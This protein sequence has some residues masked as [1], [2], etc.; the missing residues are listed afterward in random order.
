MSVLV[1]SWILTL[2]SMFS[3]SFNEEVRS[4]LRLTRF[5]AEEAQARALARSGV[6]I[7]RGVLR[8]TGKNEWDAPVEGWD[9]NPELFRRL[10]LGD[11]FVSVGRH[12][13]QGPNM[14]AVYGV[15]DE[16]RR[17]PLHLVDRE[18]L[19]RLPGMSPEAIEAV[20]SHVESGGR[21]PW[22][23]PGLEGEALASIRAYLSGGEAGGVNINTAPQ[24]VLVALGLPKSCVRKV[25]ERRNGPDG[26]VGT[27]DDEP[28]TSLLVPTGGVAELELDSDEA[29]RLSILARE[30]ALVV[31]SG[32]FR[33]RSRG[34]VAGRKSCAEIEAI[35]KRTETGTLEIVDWRESWQS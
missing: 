19:E 8:E 11:G 33:V 7:A 31:T 27:E 12:E 28:F 24:A 15:E 2:L 26:R 29:A 6:A 34:W 14:E 21:M 32:T 18:L 20:L 25:L 9:R 16:N 23:A 17:I 10:R 1:V 13:G 3:L 22:L 5:Q 30:E 35:L 4:D